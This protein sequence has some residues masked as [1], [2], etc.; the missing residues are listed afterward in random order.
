MEEKQKEILKKLTVHYNKKENRDKFISNCKK[1]AKKHNEWIQK[2]ESKVPQKYIQQI[3][4]KADEKYK[5]D[6]KE[7]SIIGLIKDSFLWTKEALFPSW[8]RTKGRVIERFLSRFILYKAVMI[9]AS[10]SYIMSSLLTGWFGISIGSVLSSILVAPITEELYKYL[11]IEIDEK[12]FGW[13]AF[14]ITEWFMYVKK[15][16]GI[17]FHNIPFMIMRFVCTLSHL[18]YTKAWADKELPKGLGIFLHAFDNGPVAWI[19]N[20]IG[21]IGQ[22]YFGIWGYW[23]SSISSMLLGIKMMLRY[24]LRL[25]HPKKKEEF[26]SEPI[27][28]TV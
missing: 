21:L 6:I 12:E 1:K 22:A 25:K 3:K 17:S 9:T 7:Y 15:F 13:F 28:Q 14:N 27:P 20:I 2:L 24:I 16:G 11:S 8:K 19:S 10:V 5:I 4:A 23:V 26:V 18:M